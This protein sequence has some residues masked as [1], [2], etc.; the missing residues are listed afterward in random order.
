MLRI[1]DANANRAREGL[2]VLEEHARLVLNDV[3]LTERIK[4]V[5]H[6]LAAAVGGLG[7]G[8]LLA[9]RNIEGDVGTD[10][11]TA[12]ERSRAAPGDVARAAARRLTESLRCIEEYGKLIDAAAA[13]QVERLRYEAYA[14]EQ[15]LF[16]GGPRR[17]RLRR[18]NLHVLVT[19][20]LC[21]LPW[22]QACEQALAGGADVLQLREKSLR[23]GELLRSAELL[24][25]LTRRHDALLI[26]ND[27]P[28]IARLAEADGVHLG[29]DDLTPSQARRILGPHALIGLSTHSVEEAS[30]ELG[31]HDSGG[32]APGY[33]GVGP[34][35]AS[36]TKPEV[37]VRGPGLL[38]ELASLT[39]SAGLPL[40]AIG[41]ITLENV[42][43]LAS[44]EA[45]AGRLAVA[46]CQS[47][48]SS[49][50]PATAARGIRRRLGVS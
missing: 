26:I 13:G 42:D 12:T 15:A 23:D 45:A 10:I 2:R 46:V 9:A 47:V 5:R 40:V 1:I 8:R 6:A 18:A 24:R 17:A 27:R 48:I 29:Q 11:T 31:R 7:E 3:A 39:A 44:V 41:G 21:A 37:A 33:L 25:T 49:R 22:E 38:A 34:M 19:E 20:S 4:Q 36:P 32:A 50:D 30:D 28:D 14:I 35:F 16:H 43:R